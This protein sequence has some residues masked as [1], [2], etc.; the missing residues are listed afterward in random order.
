MHIYDIAVIGAG[1]AG[2]MAAIRAGQLHK[3]IALIER[4]NIIGKKILLTGKGR[5]NITNNASISDF[6]KIFGF[7]GPFYRSSFFSFFHHDLI[8]FFAQKGLTLKTERQGR[9]FPATDRSAD[10]ITVLKKYLKENDVPIIFHARLQDISQKNSLFQ[11]RIQGGKIIHSGKVILASGGGSYSKTGSTGDGYRLAKKLGHTITP[12]QPGLVPLKTREPWVKELQ[13]LALKNIRITFR[14]G[15]TKIISEIG[16]L[17]FTHF[18]V[19]GPLV[20]DLSARILSLLR[21]NNEARF[22][23]DLKP[24]LRQEQLT[25][26]LLRDF[27]AAGHAGI[28]KIMKDML[29][30]RLVEVFMELAGLPPG[31][32]SNQVTRPQRQRII[33]NLKALPL[34]VTGSLRL[35]EAMVTCGGVSTKEI[36]PKS[37]ESKIVPGLYFAGEIIDGCAPS[38]GY[39]LQQAFSTGWLAGERAAYA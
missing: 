4:N 7:W 32:K 5:C 15:S 2:T 10:V 37:M 17:M 19:S 25:A 13:G 23:I 34:T 3:K 28:K 38:G 22:F 16:E 9:V 26:R 36:N 12:L 35:E 30:A 29:P 21:Q 33:D 27:R 39:N 8:D 18:G 24:A 14:S 6:I 20:L 11:L 31:Q 1:A